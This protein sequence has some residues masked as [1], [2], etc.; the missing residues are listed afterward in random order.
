MEVV[1][2]EERATV[3]G[4]RRPDPFFLFRPEEDDEEEEDEDP[5][6]FLRSLSFLSLCV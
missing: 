6:P 3:G 5:V 1:L 2:E 4:L